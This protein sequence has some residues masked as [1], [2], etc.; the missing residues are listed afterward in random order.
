MTAAILRK[1]TEAEGTVEEEKIIRTIEKLT[2]KE[3]TKPGV[4]LS[5]MRRE[6]K[7][8]GVIDR[9]ESGQLH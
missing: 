6:L 1:I 4:T 9:T 8:N 2:E 5:A 7:F 3:S